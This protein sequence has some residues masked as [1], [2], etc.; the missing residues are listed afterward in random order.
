MMSDEIIPLAAF[1]TAVLLPFFLVLRWRGL[2]LIAAILIGWLAVHMA[3]ITSIVNEPADAV[4]KGL[5]AAFGWVYMS[6]WCVIVTSALLL[7]RGLLCLIR[8]AA[9]PIS[10]S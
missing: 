5:G 3:N 9:K 1:A 8:S 6:A 7:L 10:G 4:F 2:G